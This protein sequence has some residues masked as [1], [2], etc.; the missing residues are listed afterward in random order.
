M[1]HPVGIPSP[2]EVADVAATCERLAADLAVSACELAAS[3]AALSDRLLSIAEQWECEHTSLLAALQRAGVSS[4]AACG[5]HSSALV[6]DAQ[7]RPGVT[8]EQ[9]DA[10]ACLFDAVHLLEGTL[11]TAPDP[12]ALLPPM[13]TFADVVLAPAAEAVDVVTSAAR[14]VCDASEL[15]V[16]WGGQGA[17]WYHPGPNYCSVRVTAGSDCLFPIS[18]TSPH[19][20]V[21]ADQAYALTCT[22]TADGVDIVY[23]P[24]SEQQDAPVVLSLTLSVCGMHLAAAQVRI[25]AYCDARGELMEVIPLPLDHYGVGIA[26]S[27]CGAFL[28]LSHSKHMAISVY[29]VASG[30]LLFQFGRKG[31]GKCEFNQPRG[32]CVTPSTGTLLVAES[33]N[34]RVQE[35]A[36]VGSSCTHIRFLGGKAV[37][38]DRV[39]SVVT[40]GAV[41]AVGKGSGISAGR[42]LVLDYVSGTLLRAFDGIVGTE[43]TSGP[44]SPGGT[45]LVA[46]LGIFAWLTCHAT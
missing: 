6:K 45:L 37:F 44:L 20:V 3:T 7:A 39:T 2:A 8:R 24:M 40:N 31:D 25:P 12:L 18:P 34:M 28:Y 33:K 13:P 42:I 43:F 19:N 46:G 9:L 41:I 22:W 27:N 29:D 10:L 30:T 4:V 32:L 1:Y 11:P 26:V 23:S 38:Q 15:T 16:S 21:M 14:I 17:C 35:L 36:C 5:A